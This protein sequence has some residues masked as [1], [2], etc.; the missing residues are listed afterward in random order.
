M[1]SGASQPRHDPFAN[2]RA[3]P[4][5]IEAARHALGTPGGSTGTAHEPSNDDALQRALRVRVSGGITGAGRAP[6]RHPWGALSI[7]PEHPTAPPSL[8]A[9]RGAAALAIVRRTAS[10]W[11]N[12]YV[13]HCHTKQ[14]VE[15]QRHIPV[16][17]PGSREVE[18]GAWRRLPS[19]LITWPPDTQRMEVCNHVPQACLDELQAALGPA[20]AW[21]GTLCR[22]APQVCP[23]P[24]TVYTFLYATLVEAAE[25]PF[26]AT[27][28]FVRNAPMWA[29]VREDI[30]NRT[31]DAHLRAWVR[32]APAPHTTAAH[33]PPCGAHA[34]QPAAA[35]P[36]AG[37]PPKRA[38]SLGPSA[39]TSSVGSTDPAKMARVLADLEAMM[40]G[41]PVRGARAQPEV[42]PPSSTTAAPA[43][44]S[45]GVQ[46]GGAAAPPPHSGHHL[47]SPATS[48]APP[49]AAGSAPAST[50]VQWAVE[51]AVRESVSRASVRGGVG[52]G[53]GA[54]STSAAHP[55]SAPAK[56]AW[57][58]PFTP[59]HSVTQVPTQH[60]MHVL[61]PPARPAH[62]TGRDTSRDALSMTQR[63]QALP[64]TPQAVAAFMAGAGLLP[65]GTPA[66]GAA[67]ARPPTQAPAGVPVLPAVDV[68]APTRSSVAPTAT[69]PPQ[70][71]PTESTASDTPQARGDVFSSR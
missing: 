28:E 35:T 4:A 40:S 3:P 6:R 50:P 65:D 68:D 62:T 47:K 46:R 51:E 71:P 13:T 45:A 34:G 8:T 55:P 12:K 58:S 36:P 9:N 25:D 53:A 17:A 31:L 44:P 19:V 56:G 18:L 2:D 5:A 37:A 43:R 69:S 23:D 14:Q 66:R 1:G 64:A 30:V 70:E 33:H 21:H 61:P 39:T 20:L 54:G 7:V 41:T 27:M 16:G 59:L 24:P 42:T 48:R 32:A 57:E 26:V 29:A 38:A 67:N 49:A 60:V 22:G 63:L 52:V 15:L 10:S 11:V